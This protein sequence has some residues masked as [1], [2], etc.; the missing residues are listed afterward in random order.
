MPMAL[1][2]KQLGGYLQPI[3]H[4]CMEDKHSWTDPLLVF[5]LHLHICFVSCTTAERNNTYC[6]STS[7]SRFIDFTFQGIILSIFFFSMSK[8]Q[9][10]K[11]QM[12]L[13][14]KDLCNVGNDLFRTPFS[15]RCRCLLV[16]LTHFLTGTTHICGV[17]N[18]GKH[19]WLVLPSFI[20]AKAGNKDAASEVQ[21]QSRLL[22]PSMACMEQKTYN[23]TSSEN[24]MKSE[25]VPF[26]IVKH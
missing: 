12:L 17:S 6:I 4:G 2:K 5:L 21:C 23:V 14:Y 26:L 10:A 20:L 13:V 16:P 15:K 3:R 11:L 24:S 9:V 22:L 18:P 25:D 8:H 19:L 7:Q 1:C